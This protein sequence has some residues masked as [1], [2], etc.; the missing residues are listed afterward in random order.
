MLQQTQVSRVVERFEA[1]VARWPAVTELAAAGEDQVLSMWQ[2][3][4]YYRRARRLHEAAK[5]CVTRFGGRVPERA[6]E[7]ATLPGVGRYT[8]GA[9]AS[10]VHGERAPI[11]DGNVAR[12]LLRVHGRA[13]DPSAR[14]A[15]D[16]L[17]ST[18]QDL[19]EGASSPSRLNEGLMELGALVC[20]PRAPR[21]HACPWRSRCVARR[22]GTIDRIPAVVARAARPTVH[23]DTLVMRGVRGL[24]LERRSDRGLWAGLWQTPTVEHA[25]VDAAKRFDPHE[26]WRGVGGLVAAGSFT[27]EKGGV[28]GLGGEATANDARGMATRARRGVGSSRLVQRDAPRARDGRRR[29]ADSRRS[30]SSLTRSRR[31]S[32]NAGACRCSPTGSAWPLERSTPPGRL[33]PAMPAML[34]FTV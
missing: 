27:A 6:T 18:A 28:P 12:V 10:I 4:G 5:A 31:L 17:W 15:Q 29:H 34:V 33:M 11:V 2:G 21:C 7:L 16:W 3:L 32:A 23:W 8:A 9:I 20:T 14:P 19:V 24:V 13:L 1:F 30:S 22:D 26:A 25:S